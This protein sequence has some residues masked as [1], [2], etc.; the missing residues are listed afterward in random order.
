MST[1]FA[2]KKMCFTTLSN[3][4]SLV[5]LWYVDCTLDEVELKRMFMPRAPSGGQQYYYFCIIHLD[6]W[7][8]NQRC[9][10]KY[11]IRP[12]RWNIGLFLPALFHSSQRINTPKCTLLADCCS[13]SLTTLTYWGEMGEGQEVRKSTQAAG[14]MFMIKCNKKIINIAW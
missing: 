4:M 7:Y 5:P 12:Q 13:D 2:L 3:V 14:K 9:Y 8:R 11:Y 10:R 1:V 6:A